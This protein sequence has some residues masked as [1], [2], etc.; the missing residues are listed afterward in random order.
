MTPVRLGGGRGAHV[1]GRAGV[2]A[3]TAQEGIELQ[4]AAGKPMS[5]LLHPRCVLPLRGSLPFPQ[6]WLPRS[7]DL[8]CPLGCQRAPDALHR[9]LAQRPASPTAVRRRSAP[10]TP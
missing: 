7:P 6:P 9:Q 4:T 2:C 5:N 1:W 10:E 8:E 3:H